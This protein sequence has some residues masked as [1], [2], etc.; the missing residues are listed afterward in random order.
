MQFDAAIDTIHHQLTDH[1]PQRLRIPRFIPAAVIIPFFR[2]NDQAH[3]LFTLRSDTVEH[4]KGQVS[5][6][7]GAREPQDDTLEQTARR[8]T[9]EEVGI[10]ADAITVI[11]QLDDFPTISDFLVTPFVGTIPYP[12]PSDP[13]HHEVAD[14]LEV[15]LDLFLSDRHFEIEERTYK[16][17]RWPVY[18]YYFGDAVIWGVTGYIINRF[19]EQ[20]FGYN[21]APR[22]I[23]GDPIDPRIGP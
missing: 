2:K 4:H 1:A 3:I 22:S 7:G 17:R 15:P 6:P 9:E 13:N 18:Y 8:E 19:V 16:G 5:F 12:Y 10:P 23:P 14:L 21:P 11:G 20:V